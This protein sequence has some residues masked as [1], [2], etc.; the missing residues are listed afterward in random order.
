MGDA[1]VESVL[2][3]LDFRE[4]GGYTRDIVEVTPVEAW[5]P[6]VRALLY[7]ANPENP[8]FSPPADLEATAAVIAKA[9][10]PSGDNAEYLLRLATFLESVGERDAH[11]EGLAELVRR[12]QQGGAQ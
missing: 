5:R 3:N 8:H 6:A 4:K 9:V 1:D 11:V 12:S 10:G 2:G 7:T